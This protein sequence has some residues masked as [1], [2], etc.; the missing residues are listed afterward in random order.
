MGTFDA[1][2]VSDLHLGA[3]NARTGQFLHFLDWMRTDLLILAGDVF[4]HPDLRWIDASSLRV[5]DALSA[6]SL[7]HRVI[8]LR[9]NHDPLHNPMPHARIEMCDE[10][11]LDVGQ[12]R[13]LVC[14]GHVWDQSMRLPAWII[15]GAD[16]AYHLAQKLD[17]THRLA[18]GLKRACKHFCRAVEALQDKAAAAAAVRKLDGVIIGHSH[19]ARNSQRHGVHCLNSGC[20]TEAPSSFVGIRA[21]RVRRYYWESILRRLAPAASSVP[22]MKPGFALPSGACGALDM[23][24]VA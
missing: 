6:F 15:G 4:D 3:R 1:V 16:A 19:V 18:R 23:P 21:G 12:R 17:R 13:Y 20:W 9:G 7:R 2:I 8:W 14:H 11:V 22:A 24:E 5:M 10:T